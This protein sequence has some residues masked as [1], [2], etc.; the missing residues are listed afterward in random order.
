M[1]KVY[2]IDKCN[3]TGLATS[4]IWCLPV[5][6]LSIIFPNLTHIH[7]EDASLNQRLCTLPTTG[8]ANFVL[9][10]FWRHLLD[11]GAADTRK[12]NCPCVFLLYDEIG[13]L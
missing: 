5:L 13:L 3:T 6:Y 11:R 10:V 9:N 4:G 2:F 1:E 12:F 7:E 8:N